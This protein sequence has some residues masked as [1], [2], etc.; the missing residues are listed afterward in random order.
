MNTKARWMVFRYQVAVRTK[1]RLV[2]KKRRF[3]NLC[4]LGPATELQG[5]IDE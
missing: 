1:R 5:A 4:K 2:R 3:V